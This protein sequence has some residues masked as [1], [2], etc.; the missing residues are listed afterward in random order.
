M[1]ILR[2]HSAE[3]TPVYQKIGTVCHPHRPELVEEGLAHMNIPSKPADPTKQDAVVACY[4]TG[5]IIGVCGLVVCE[6]E[7]LVYYERRG[8]RGYPSRMTKAVKPEPCSSLTTVVR[9]DGWRWCLTTNWVGYANS[10]PE[11]GCAAF[12]KASPEQQ[13]QW[14][15]FWKRHALVSEC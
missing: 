1:Y 8:D 5:R 9:W 13:A 4:D 7:D 11:P 10:C 12:K 3:G 15:A 2:G 6:D 14:A